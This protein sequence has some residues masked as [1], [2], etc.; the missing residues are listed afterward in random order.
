MYTLLH[1]GVQHCKFILQEDKKEKVIIKKRECENHYLLIVLNFSLVIR[2]IKSQIIFAKILRKTIEAKGETSCL[3]WIISKLHKSLT[4]GNTCMGWRKV[5][6]V[7]F[8]ILVYNLNSLS[9]SD[10]GF[11]YHCPAVSLWAREDHHSMPNG[12]SVEF[13]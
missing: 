12:R 8:V 9:T 10:F 1:L 13:L 5:L 4:F 2:I 3:Y 6:K 11:D 7:N